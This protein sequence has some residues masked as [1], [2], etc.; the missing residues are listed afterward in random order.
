MVEEVGGGD[1][2]ID[3]AS[4][5]HADCFVGGARDGMM[6]CDFDSIH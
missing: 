3:D 6:L 4:W 5:L 2:Q 1:G